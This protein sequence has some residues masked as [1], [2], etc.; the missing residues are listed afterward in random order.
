MSPT[1]ASLARVAALAL[2]VKHTQMMMRMAAEAVAVACEKSRRRGLQRRVAVLVRPPARAPRESHSE[3][4][5][6]DDEE[7]R[8]GAG[9]LDRAEV[10]GV[11]LGADL[12]RQVGV[13]DLLEAR[14]VDV[15]DAA[16]P[17]V[18]QARLVRLEVP[19][20]QEQRRTDGDTR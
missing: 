19:V 17:D 4:L 12:P 16:L 14:A 11:D 6:R 15:P 10:Q 18:S 9:D 20:R 1:L 3:E 2:N 5:R 8:E 13:L 7:Q